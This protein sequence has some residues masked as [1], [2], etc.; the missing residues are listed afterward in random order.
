MEQT[1]TPEFRQSRIETAGLLAKRYKEDAGYFR[2]EGGALEEGLAIERD[3]WAN[4][5]E[6][7]LE[8]IGTV[9]QEALAQG[10]DEGHAVGVEDGRAM[11]DDD[12]MPYET[13]NPHK[14]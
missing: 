14:S 8:E 12:A 6:F 3:A 11:S 4:T 13:P 2:R 9:R 7:L 5:I 10:W 1:I